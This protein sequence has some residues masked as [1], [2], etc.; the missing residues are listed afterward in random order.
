MDRSRWMNIRLAVTLV[1]LI[2]GGW[3]LSAGADDDER[4]ETAYGREQGEYHA[5]GKPH[6]ES[7]EREGN[8]RGERRSDLPVPDGRGQPEF[9]AAF[10]AWKAECSSCHMAY[11]PR[12][13]PTDSW[14]ALMGGLSDHFGTD[15]SLDQETVDRIL[16]LL[17]QYAGRRRSQAGTG[18]VLRITD[19]RWFRHEHDEV[20]S[21]VWKRP[22][23]G[24]PSNCMACHAG[25]EQGDFDE[26]AVRIPR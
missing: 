17:E 8:E 1:L 18:L 20:G 12:L 22:A 5:R 9:K 26:D 21:A 6:R 2:T 3:V 15:A 23:V 19:T 4:D 14:R 7:H 25:A 16:P 24:S 10:E 13:L 11:P